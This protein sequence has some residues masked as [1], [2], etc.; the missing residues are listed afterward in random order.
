[1]TEGLKE[2]RK[3]FNLYAATLGILVLSIII[4]RF[5]TRFGLVQENMKIFGFIVYPEDVSAI[6][7]ILFGV[8]V[9]ILSLQI[10]LF[11]I[12]LKPYMHFKPDEC[13]RMAMD[14]LYF[15]WVA[16]P[17][18]A[19]KISLS[20]FWCG[21]VSGCLVVLW[22]GVAHVLELVNTSMPKAFRVIGYFDFL[23][24]A[25]AL[26]LLWSTKNNIDEIRGMIVEMQGLSHD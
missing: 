6:I 22:I 5:N 24:L 15:P 1:M 16:S 8:F 3:T 14:I 17:F 2:I 25:A 9:I 18:H 20:L 21:I 19:S 13:Y 26:L 12:G 10:R 4:G 11:K 23:V 7:G